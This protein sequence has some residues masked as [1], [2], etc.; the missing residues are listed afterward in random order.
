MLKVPGRLADHFTKYKPRLAFMRSI[1]AISSGRSSTVTTRWIV[2]SGAA[3][4]TR[5]EV[6]GQNTL[7]LFDGPNDHIA[8]SLH[9]P[10]AQAIFCKVLNRATSAH[11]IASIRSR[12]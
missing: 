1:A 10:A 3:H 6:F 7:R 11:F 2:T 4:R 9:Q 12:K 5:F 8:I